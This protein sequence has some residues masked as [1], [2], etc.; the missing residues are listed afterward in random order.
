MDAVTVQL[1]QSLGKSVTELEVARAAA[2]QSGAHLKYAELT[3]RLETMRVVIL[4]CQQA[5]QA[6]QPQTGDNPPPKKAKT[7]KKAS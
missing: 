1:I 4:F 5:V 3:G 6:S 7:P 2:A